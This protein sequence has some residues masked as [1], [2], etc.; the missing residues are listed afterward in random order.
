MQA[1]LPELMLHLP[2]YPPYLILTASAPKPLP[3]PPRLTA[4]AM[5]ARMSASQPWHPQPPLLP[6]NLTAMQ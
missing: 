4:H 5:T 6:P 2:P 3:L 1:H